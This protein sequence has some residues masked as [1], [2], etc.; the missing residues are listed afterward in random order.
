[1]AMPAASA[2]ERRGEADL[3]PLVEHP[4]AGGLDDACHDLGQRRLA[5]AV[6][7]EQRMDLRM[8]QGEVD[9]V[10]RRHAAIGL[11]DLLHHDDVGH[12][13]LP[14]LKDCVAALGGDQHAG[15]TPERRWL[16]RG[17]S[18]GAAVVAGNRLQMAIEPG[19]QAVGPARRPRLVNAH[20]ADGAALQRLEEALARRQARGRSSAR[21]APRSSW[22][23]DSRPPAARIRSSRL[24][25]ANS[26]SQKPP[27][28]ARP[29]APDSREAWRAPARRARS[30]TYP[31]EPM[32]PAFGGDQ[33]HRRRHASPPGKARPVARQAASPLPGSMRQ[34]EPSAFLSHQV[35]GPI[36]MAG[37]RREPC[38]T[39]RPPLGPKA[40]AVGQNGPSGMAIWRPADEQPA[41]VERDRQIAR[42][43]GR[44]GCHG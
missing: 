21:A 28:A 30:R 26:A 7:A 35:D 36:A 17:A 27:S 2:S 8:A 19:D 18:V 22:R 24:R 42:R 5:G 29:A 44:D 25:G 13:Q 31:D 10:D 4:A 33:P 39:K 3:P 34:T 20:R 15:P 41:V 40:S 23:R 1:M 38:V 43:R 6:L 9:V 16:C 14:D 32:A 11:G 12:R 37:C